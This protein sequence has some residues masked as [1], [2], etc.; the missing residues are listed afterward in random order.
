MDWLPG[1]LLGVGGSQKIPEYTEKFGNYFRKKGWLGFGKGSD[2]SGVGGGREGKEKGG[3]AVRNGAVVE[4]EEIDKGK[5]IGTGKREKVWT[6]GERG[7]RVLV[8]FATAYAITK[9]FLPVRIMVSLWGT[10]WFARR[11]L[12]I[13]GWVRKRGRS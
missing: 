4:V 5:W 3:V 2:K 1:W 11:V 13:F 9:V 12:G 10:P 7:S 6:V 8:E